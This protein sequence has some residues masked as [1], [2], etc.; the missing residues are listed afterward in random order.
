MTVRSKY[1]FTIALIGMSLLFAACSQK[2]IAVEPTH[3]P[4]REL[5]SLA[6]VRVSDPQMLNIQNLNHQYLLSLDLDRL[7]VCYRKEAGL[8]TLGHEQYAG[9]E[10]E[11]VWGGGPLSGHMIGFWLSAMA[12][13]YEATGDES[14]LPKVEYALKSLR[15]CQ[16]AHG[17]GFLGAQPDIKA[18]YAEVA[19]GEFK[20]SNP[21]VNHMWAPV[22]I[23]NKLLLGFYDVYCTFNLPLAKSIMVDF[24]DWFGTAIIDKLDHE[25]LQRLL[26]CEHGSINESYVNVYAVTGEQRFLDW[27][28]RLNDEDMWIPAA[29][30]RDVLHGWHANTQIPKFTGMERIYSYTNNQDFYRASR[31]FW[32]VVVDRHTWGNGGNSM[33]EHFFPIN[34]F[35]EKITNIGGPESCNSVN[36]MR[37][38]EALYQND[39]EMKYIDYYERVLFNH[40]VA[41]YEPEEGMCV[42]FTSMR[43]AHYKVYYSKYESFW[44]CTATGIQAPAKFGKMIYAKAKD[45]LF[46][47]LYTCSTVKWEEKGMTISQHTTFPVENSI[48]LTIDDCQKSREATIALRHPWWSKDIEVAVNGQKVEFT[49]EEGYVILNREWNKNDEIIITLQ[50]TLRAEAIP[51]GNSYHAFFYGPIMLGTRIEDASMTISDYRMTR[52]N[53]ATKEIPIDNAPEISSDVQALISTMKRDDK[54]GLLRFYVPDEQAT[55]AF[56]LEP[57]NNIHFSRYAVY[58]RDMNLNKK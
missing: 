53:I 48:S 16:E 33:G 21:L 6:D 49:E 35:Q 9:W 28:N 5:F 45:R 47:N 13:S 20:T 14:V 25:Q 55:K 38:T 1:I 46:V 15:E 23:I 12:M 19:K 7:L 8:P 36:M 32:Q 39:G 42:Y 58:L 56:Y 34:E 40:I 51:G 18:F 44:C 27:A 30:G 4:V 57:Y 52:N 11:D 3:K 50:P 26:V 17:D 54:D 41:N 37:L 29:E 24:A 2:Q 22:Y 10:S 31:F 43:P